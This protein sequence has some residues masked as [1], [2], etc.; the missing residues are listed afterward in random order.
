MYDC[1]AR[2]AQ[3]GWERPPDLAP[4]LAAVVHEGGGRALAKRVRYR[5]CRKPFCY[6]R[7]FPRRFHPDH[8]LEVFVG[9]TAVALLLQQQQPFVPRMSVSLRQRTRRVEAKT[10]E[11]CAK[12]ETKTNQNT[13]RF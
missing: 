12:L 8:D 2:L 10:A 1:R 9:L 7:L 6:R 13:I 11:D 4:L 3:D 5:S